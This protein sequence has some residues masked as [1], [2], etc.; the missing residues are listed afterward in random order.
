MLTTVLALLFACGMEQSIPSDIVETSEKQIVKEK[1]IVYSGRSE[2]LVG[3]LFEKMEQ[4][5]QLDIEVQYGT[6][7]E[8]ATRFLTEGEQS[9]ADIIFAQDSGHLGALAKQD[10]LA[11]LSPDL[12]AN[13][14]K[15]FQAEDGT[16]VGTSS[17]LRVL[18]YDSK[19]ITPE[20]LPK[21]L[22]ELSDPK[23]KGKLGW[24]PGNGSFQAHLS[25]LQC[26][27]RRRNK[28]LA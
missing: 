21:S 7:S 25:V 15:R 26:M 27:G 23:W 6:T 10:S 9:P 17:R 22:K 13:V 12:L 2:S 18:V 16:W 1:V 14:E 28:G 20:E 19:Q 11:T 24:A 3:E 5:L 8:M 4:E